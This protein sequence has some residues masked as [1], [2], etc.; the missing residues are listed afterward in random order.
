M[1]E[2]A[3]SMA[4]QNRL[5]P[6]DI[7][8]L[9]AWISDL[10]ALGYRFPAI[11]KAQASAPPQRSSEPPTAAAWMTTGALDG[12]YV[13]PQ[14]W[15]TRL[16]TMLVVNVNRLDLD[17]LK[18]QLRLLHA[19]YRPHYR[20]VVFAG[21]DLTRRVK[22]GP[23][24]QE[25]MD[26]G[27]LWNC[28]NHS[29]RAPTPGFF[30]YACVSEGVLAAQEA[31]WRPHQEVEAFN[32]FYINDDVAYSPCMAQQLNHSKVWYPGH[33]TNLT[34]LANMKGWFWD[35]DADGPGT[36]TLREVLTSTFATTWGKMARL[37]DG[38]LQP[39]QI[40][41]NNGQGDMYYVPGRHMQMFAKLAAHFQSYWVMS[42]A[43]VFNML[44][45]LVDGPEDLD[46]VGF[47]M[48]WDGARECFDR[49]I[50]QILP[51]GAD[52]SQAH[53]RSCG[54]NMLTD[55]EHGTEAGIFAIHPVK[56]SIPAVSDQWLA[57]WLSQDHTGGNCT[58]YN[59]TQHLRGSS[60]GRAPHA[61]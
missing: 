12:V 53:V 39:M 33:L 29:I 54:A 10:Q 2:A 3:N 36:L 40:P 26:Q 49:G 13:F 57:W 7:A 52:I 44:S 16:D 20:R 42:E 18:K 41:R 38:R 4:D 58:I 27:Y 28:G 45:L 9:L 50:K 14:Q 1:L 15:C 61:G 55:E 60:D 8:L 6:R 21:S 17:G 23:R 46:V 47:A 32:M 34:D 31:V 51:L 5:Q 19:A 22:P 11:A 48:A 30:S 59:R 43:A 37:A 35:T 56:M 25:L 24:E